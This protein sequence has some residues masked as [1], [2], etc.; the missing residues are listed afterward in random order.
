MNA[1][2]WGVGW[3]TIL[4]VRLVLRRR[5][6]SERDGGEAVLL[7]ESAGLQVALKGEKTQLQRRSVARHAQQR[8]TDAAALKLAEHG[9]LP[10][11]GHFECEQSQCFAAIVRDP[12]FA[13]RN[14]VLAK[15]RP[16]IVERVALML[17]NI[18]IACDVGFVPAAGQRIEVALAVAPD[19]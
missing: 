4:D 6:A 8:R 18:R 16:R 9:E 11:P 14:N 7:V 1:S 3:K 13:A 10:Y 19:P 17:G 5:A 15:E 12:D 2:R